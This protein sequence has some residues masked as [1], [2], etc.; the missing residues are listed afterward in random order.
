ML[1]PVAIS[2]VEA[3]R[4]GHKNFREAGIESAYCGDPA[5]AT[6]AEGEVTYEILAAMVTEEVLRSLQSRTPGGVH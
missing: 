5:A 6:A 3:I 1:P 4:A 2:L